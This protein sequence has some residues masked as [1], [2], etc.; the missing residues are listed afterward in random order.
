MTKTVRPKSKPRVNQDEIPTVR[1][2]RLMSC[3]PQSL[4]L[5]RER[6]PS[7][8][9]ATL[10]RALMLAEADEALDRSRSTPSLT[11]VRGTRA[12]RGR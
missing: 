7:P 10:A 9:L 11:P 6:V 3:A 12:R 2:P 5:P 1:P 4:T 8:G